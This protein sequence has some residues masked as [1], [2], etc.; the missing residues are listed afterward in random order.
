MADLLTVAL[1][2]E[3]VAHERFLD[4][5]LRRIAAETGRPMTLRTVSARGGHARALAELRAFQKVGPAADF[6]VAAVDAN[7]AG[8]SRARSEIENAIDTARFPRHAI[9]CPDPH[10][11][12]WYLAD[13]QSLWEFLRVRVTLDKRKCE[14]DLYKHRL[15]QALA[16]AGHV[17]ALGGAEF[18]TEIVAAMDLYRAGKNERSLKCFLDAIRPPL[19]GGA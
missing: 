6:V 2:C 5:L 1:F 18:A 9:A 19:E 8:W 4:A 11:E 3:D 16:N 10:I 13:P 17:V 15:A 12:R 14:R 7:C